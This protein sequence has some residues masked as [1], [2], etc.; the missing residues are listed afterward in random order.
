MC[1]YMSDANLLLNG[2]SNIVADGGTSLCDSIE[3]AT[4]RHS[5]ILKMETITEMIQIS[6]VRKKYGK[7][8]SIKMIILNGVLL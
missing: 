3:Y 8:T 5:T 6:D 4:D 7:M 1:T 2:I